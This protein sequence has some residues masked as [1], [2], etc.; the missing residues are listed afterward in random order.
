LFFLP[1]L[2]L[3]A[4][5]YPRRKWQKRK[6][7]HSIHMLDCVKVFLCVDS[8]IWFFVNRVEVPWWIRILVATRRVAREINPS[9][10]YVSGL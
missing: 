3:W 4:S 9:N 1:F 2:L 6:D 5:R 10:M 7:S 8:L